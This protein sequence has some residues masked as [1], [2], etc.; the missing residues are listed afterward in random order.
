MHLETAAVVLHTP[1]S[2]LALGA[3]EVGP[4][5]GSLVTV[6]PGR[7]PRCEFVPL[8]P[9][10]LEQSPLVGLCRAAA[11]ELPDFR[12]RLVDLDP[13]SVFQ[14]PERSVANL[15]NEVLNG[16]METEVAY[17]CG[18]RLVARL[19]RDPSLVADAAAGAAANLAV[20]HGTPF[21]LRITQ[22]GSIDAL[23][24]VSVEREPPAAGQVELEVHAAGLNFSDVLKALGLYPGIRDAIVPLGVAAL[25]LALY[26]V[27]H[28][29]VRRAKSDSR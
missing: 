12:P 14:S 6:N 24:L 9:V 13:A 25:G 19:V 15:L 17:R 10:A 8:S 20:P 4:R 3:G 26:T 7:L 29:S 23:R 11:M 27:L 22:A 16:S 2:L 18:R 1:G 21:Q 28:P 5:G